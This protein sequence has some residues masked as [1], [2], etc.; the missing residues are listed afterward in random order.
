MSVSA[1]PRSSHL[2]RGELMA[3]VEGE[4]QQEAAVVYGPFPCAPIADLFLPINATE[5]A[6]A[7]SYCCS[8]PYA[9]LCRTNAERTQS[10]GVWGG[11]YYIDGTRSALPFSGS[12]A[13]RTMTDGE[14]FDDDPFSLEYDLDSH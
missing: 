5:V 14:A 10:S 4:E 8:C 12:R 13:V 9:R 2:S 1:E 11:E 3:R 6:V 7:K